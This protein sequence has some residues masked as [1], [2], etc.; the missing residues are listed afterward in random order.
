[1]TSHPIEGVLPVLHVSYLPDGRIDLDDVERELDWVYQHG[2][3]G[4]CLA[5]VTDLFRLTTSERYDLVEQVVRLNADRGAVIVSVGAESTEQAV[6]HA[7]HAR[8][9]GADAVMALP[10]VNTRS[11]DAGAHT[12]FDSLLQ[13]VEIPLIIQDAS[14]YVGRPLS[15]EIQLRLLERYGPERLLFKPET[16]PVGP[17]V[18]ALVQSSHGNAKIFEGSGGLYLVETFRRGLSGVMPGCDLIDGIVALWKALLSGDDKRIYQLAFPISAIIAM[19]AQAGLDGF[20]MIERYILRKRGIFC[21]SHNRGP[22]GFAPDKFVLAEVDR[23]LEVLQ[24][25]LEA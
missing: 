23:L 5:M 2:S 24:Q 4:C 11:D 16:V 25:A 18:T 3:Q 1:M 9:A 8:D 6:A 17:T 7:R 13:A 14:G 19:Q 12:Y 20:M 15:L 10:P 22:T 21:S